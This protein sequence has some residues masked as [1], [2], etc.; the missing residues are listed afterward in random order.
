VARSLN[1]AHHQGG[2]QHDVTPITPPKLHPETH[3]V[4]GRSRFVFRRDDH[5]Q[6]VPSRAQTHRSVLENYDATHSR[7]GNQKLAVPR[8][9]INRHNPC[10]A[11]P[12]GTTAKPMRLPPWDDFQRGPQSALA[13]ILHSGPHR[14]S[15]TKADVCQEKGE[16]L[17]CILEQATSRSDKKD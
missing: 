12:I 5:T 9:S 1:P 15:F 14:K 6:M 11:F 10:H 3:R 13:E 8:N 2:R 7:W 4:P 16:S 17:L